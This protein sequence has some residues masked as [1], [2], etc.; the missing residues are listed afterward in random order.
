MT[1]LEFVRL[2]GSIYEHSPWIA[3]ETYEEQPF[4]NREDLTFALRAVVESSSDEAKLALIRAHP[5]LGGKLA[6]AGQL[7]QESTKEQAGLGLDRLSDVE[8]EKFETLNT[9]YLAKFGFPFIICAKRH[10]RAQVLAAFAKR[11]ENTRGKE[12]EEALR[13]IHFIAQMRLEEKVEGG[14]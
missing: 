12:I 10:T 5:D 3:E 4:S 9:A 14:Q 7:T 6:R 13:Q 1:K 2:L 11:I 8:Y